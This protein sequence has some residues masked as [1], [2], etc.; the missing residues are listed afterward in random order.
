MSTIKTNN[1][2][3]KGLQVVAWIIFIGLSIEAGAMCVNFAFSLFKPAS[4]PVLYQS[5]DLSGLYQ[6]N[7]WAFFGMYSFVLSISVL[8]AYLFYIVIKLVSRINLKKPFIREVST[9]ILAI[10]YV[11]FLIGLLSAIA[12]RSADSLQY[13]G[14]PIDM[15]HQYWVDSQAFILMAGIV[16]VIAIIFSKGVEYQEEIEETV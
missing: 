15:L 8:K 10:A 7:Q 1:Y 9:Q 4:V 12:K 2:L 16:Y 11:T 13:H 3:L 6:S 5:L 14:Y